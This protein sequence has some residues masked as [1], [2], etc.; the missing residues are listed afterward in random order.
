[1]MKYFKNERMIPE[2][3][4]HL[5]KVYDKMPESMPECFKKSKLI[6]FDEVKVEHPLLST[7]YTVSIKQHSM[8]DKEY[9][10]KKL[11]GFVEISEEEYD[12]LYNRC[13]R[14]T[15]AFEEIVPKYDWKK[16]EEI[17]D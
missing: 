17:E 2:R 5:Y 16:Y 7:T 8:T 1:M 10:D 13:A 4:L 12:S 15:E 11:W 3:G 14:L 6:C 9:L